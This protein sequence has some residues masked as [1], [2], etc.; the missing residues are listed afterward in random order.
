MSS[1]DQESVHSH[2]SIFNPDTENDKRRVWNPDYFF[3]IVLLISG[4]CA[5]PSEACS[6]KGMY[7]V[8]KDHCSK[9]KNLSNPVDILYLNRPTAQQEYFKEIYEQ[10]GWMWISDANKLGP[11]HTGFAVSS[12]VL[13]ILVML[14]V[15]G[16][17]IPQPH[18]PFVAYTVPL[19]LYVLYML[20]SF[21]LPGSGSGIADRYYFKPQDLGKARCWGDAATLAF[22]CMNIGY[23]VLPFLAARNAPRRRSYVDV[24]YLGAACLLFTIITSYSFYALAGYFV[25]KVRTNMPTQLALN[26]QDL[27][28][29]YFP[30]LMNDAPPDVL[31]SVLYFF[32][33]TSLG[34]GSL[35]M[36]IVC[37][38]GELSSLSSFRFRKPIIFVAVG[39]F[40]AITGLL[41]AN[42]GASFLLD[43]ME[44]PIFGSKKV[45]LSLLFVIV[46]IFLYGRNNMIHHIEHRLQVTPCPPTMLCRAFWWV[47][48]PLG[49]AVLP[50]LAAVGRGGAV[51]D[52]RTPTLLVACTVIY[53]FYYWFIIGGVTAWAW[54][55]PKKPRGVWRLE[56]DSED[57]EVA[58]PESFQQVAVSEQNSGDSWQTC[59]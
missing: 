38:V 4:W 6:S 50:I 31:W 3:D 58:T 34:V 44:S 40:G 14:G 9:E 55:Q 11:M 26:G 29:V 8:D 53:E 33:L 48:C 10:R 21:C 28:R 57:V 5:E 24:L 46:V 47:V 27:A 59:A 20:I 13:W 16:T 51:F 39:L 54:F 37:I 2:S 17:Q 36:H 49:L 30:T 18:I 56:R 35:I 32:V 23:G 22:A 41:F 19:A 7:Y 12:F 25:K 42:K 1:E 52:K 15:F 45:I 43:S